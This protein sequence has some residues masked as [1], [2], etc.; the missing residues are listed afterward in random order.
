MAYGPKSSGKTAKKRIKKRGSESETL[1]ARAYKATAEDMIIEEEPTIEAS[2]FLDHLILLYG[3][4]KIGKTTFSTEIEG[5]YMIAT[6]PGF[7]SLKCRKTHITS[8]VGF[9]TFIETIEKKKKLLKKLS[10]FSVDT[11]DNLAKF[12]MQYTCGRLEIGHPSD[13]QW[14]K[15]WE[16]YRDEFTYWI[17]RLCAIGKG[18]M[19]I[20]HE[21]E[22]EIVHE[23]IHTNKCVP[24]LPKTCYTVINN[25]VDFIIRMGYDLDRKPRSKSKKKDSKTLR[26]LLLRSHSLYDA[27]NRT[28]V[29]VPDKIFF[30]TEKEAYK[31]LQGFFE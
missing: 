24:A 6:E 26:C 3:P 15:G 21:S 20:S 23:G 28:K 30:K 1:N 29:G 25:L 7:K 27:G 12:C 22:K 9:R 18:V 2:D 11:V 10:L 4:P 13:L 5:Q 8:W 31:K 14:G 16:A 19:F 17:L